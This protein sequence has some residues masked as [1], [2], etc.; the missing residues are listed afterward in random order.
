MAFISETWKKYIPEDIQQKY[1]IYDY[2]HAAAI[3]YTEFPEHFSDVCTVLRNFTISKSDITSRGGNESNIPKKFSDILRPMGWEE[4][5][6]HA[7]VIVDD[8]EISHDTHLVDYM[9]GRVA[10]DLEW[11]SKDQ[12]YDRDLYAFKSFFDYDKLSLGILVTRS[13]DLNI[14]FTD[15]GTYVAEDGTE[16]KYMAKYGA[17][18]TQMGKLLPRLEAGRNGGCPI[19]VFGITRK[20]IVEDISNGYTV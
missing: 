8:N 2:K 1:E 11:N 13:T 14:Y 7:R 9:K 17:S 16:K 3:L 19:L 15:L 12:T 18:T 20:A 6:L 5:K 10:F 4:K